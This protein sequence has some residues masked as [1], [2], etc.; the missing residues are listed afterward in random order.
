LE[1]SLDRLEEKGELSEVFESDVD[2]NVVS[3][4][5]R[6]VNAVPVPVEVAE[7]VAA[8]PCG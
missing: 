2:M 3:R 4:L 7:V 6:L 5:P 8:L 1:E